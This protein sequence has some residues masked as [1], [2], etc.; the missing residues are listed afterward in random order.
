MKGK[1][2]DERSAETS[3]FSDERSIPGPT[4]RGTIIARK[5]QISQR[6]PAGAA[7]TSRWL[8]FEDPGAAEILRTGCGE[9]IMTSKNPEAS[10]NATRMPARRA[11]GRLPFLLPLFV[12]AAS[13]AGAGPIEII[14]LAGSIPGNALIQPRGVAV[15][16]SGNV[17]VAGGFRSNN[18]FK[19]TPAGVITEII[20]DTGDGAG[21]SL[22]EPSDLAADASGNVYVTGAGSSNVFEITAGG[23]ITEIIDDTGDGLGNSLSVPRGVA[24]DASGN[25]YVTG[26]ITDNAFEITPGG[27]ITEIIDSTGD[28][29]VNPL[30]QP[31]GIAVDGSGNVYVA[32]RGSNNVFEITPGGGDHRDHRQ[33]RRRPGQLGHRAPGRRGRRI[34]KRLRGG[35]LQ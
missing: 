13:A 33:H 6:R 18:V 20:D 1:E 2:R 23:V 27:V 28:G 29:G 16:G 32:G 14:D 10:R 5:T 9:K 31:F 21:N 8:G 11:A 15:D 22:L 7:P 26:V 19:I 17:Y 30:D 12:L 34:R 35:S 25:V 4:S 24:V 3:E